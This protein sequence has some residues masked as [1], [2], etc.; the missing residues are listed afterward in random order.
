[1]LKLNFKVGVSERVG[2][3]AALTSIPVM[4]R[5][6]TQAPDLVACA[7]NA[8]YQHEVKEKNVQM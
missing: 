2:S 1:M 3:N 7:P 5:K 6:V 8:H 4:S